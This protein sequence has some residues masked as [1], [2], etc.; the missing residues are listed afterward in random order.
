MAGLEAHYSARDIEARMLATVPGCRVDCIE[1]SADS[2]AGNARR[3]LE[4]GQVRLV[5]GVFRK[6]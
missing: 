6:Q 1:M 5:P 4:E 2:C 3:S